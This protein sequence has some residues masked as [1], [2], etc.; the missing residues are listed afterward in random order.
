M[1]IYYTYKLVHKHT[2]QEYFGC[3]QTPLSD[4]YLDLGINYFSSSKIVKSIG[5]EN[6]Y[7]GVVEVYDNREDCF[8]AEQE[9]IRSILHSGKCLNRFY[10]RKTDKAKIFLPVPDTEETRLKKSLAAKGKPKPWR[11]GIPISDE[12]KKKQ[13]EGRRKNLETWTVEKLQSRNSAIS[14]SLKGKPKNYT[15]I[16]AK[17][18]ICRISDKKELSK[19]SAA[20]CFPELK[21]YF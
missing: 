15:T 21:P 17:K 3:R 14:N 9:L 13:N 11:Q 18:F 4:P 5:F 12:L 10:H 19:P 20:L 1:N 16:C 2:G 7:F 8:W 6:F